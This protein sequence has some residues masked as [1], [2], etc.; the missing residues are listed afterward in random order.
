MALPDGLITPVV[1]NAGDKG[2]TL[3]DEELSLL[4][5]KARDRGLS[6][7]EYSNATF[8]ISNL[9]NYGIEEFTAIINPPG[10]AILA[11]GEIKKEPVAGKNDTVELRQMMRATLSCDHRII[12]GAV[13]AAFLNQ[14]VQ[15]I[16]NPGRVLF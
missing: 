13:G 7:E 5:A 3:I 15:F 12:D 11:L 9:G 8:S 2:I 6:P 14:L 4:I 16:E 10:S 1:R